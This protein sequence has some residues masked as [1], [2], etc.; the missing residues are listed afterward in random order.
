MLFPYPQIFYALLP[1][2]IFLFPTPAP[3]APRDV[4]A[5]LVSGLDVEV[6]WRAPAIPNGQI[7]HYTVYGIPIVSFG[8]SVEQRRKR[9]SNIGVPTGSFHKVAGLE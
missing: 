8:P 7:I 9:Q 1:L 5:R 4:S 3:S 2:Y 6:T